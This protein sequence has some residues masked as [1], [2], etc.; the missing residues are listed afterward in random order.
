MCTRGPADP[1]TSIASDRGLQSAGVGAAGIVVVAHLR[2]CCLHGAVDR[3]GGSDIFQEL[4]TNSSH[5]TSSG[6]SYC[7]QLD[8][9]SFS[10]RHHRRLSIAGVV[11]YEGTGHGGGWR[12]P[13][14]GWT[15]GL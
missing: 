10:L 5:G 13:N 14:S 12:P 4:Q 8:C 6:R 2:L 3:A 15:S 11:V 9:L 7:N 1:P